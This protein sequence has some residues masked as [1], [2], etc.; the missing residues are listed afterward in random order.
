MFLVG[1]VKYIVFM[2]LI[3]TCHDGWLGP[4]DWEQSSRLMTFLNS[5]VECILD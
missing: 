4:I 2:R 1:V 5:W 3:T